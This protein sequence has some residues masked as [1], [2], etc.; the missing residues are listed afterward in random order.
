MNFEVQRQLTVALE[1]QPG[2]LA[3]ISQVVSGSGINIEALSVTDNVEQGHIRLMT[4]D[5]PRCKELLA[6]R[7]FYVV[8]ADV[9]AIHVTD[10]LGKLAH[11]SQ[12]LATAKVNIDYAYGSVDHA[13]AQTR[14]IVKVS[15]LKKAGAVIAAL[16]DV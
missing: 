16:S 3:R 13:G 5:P 8:E 14:L 11:I 10:S 6:S 2:A 15:N 9:L 4:S 12:A 1:N 7:G